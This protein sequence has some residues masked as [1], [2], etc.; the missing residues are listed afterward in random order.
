MADWPIRI[1]GRDGVVHAAAWWVK[2][3][4][5]R[6]PCGMAKGRGTEQVDRDMTCPACIEKIREA[7][8]ARGW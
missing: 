1:L 3:G 8:Q 5:Y 7:D 2:A 4:Q 6:T